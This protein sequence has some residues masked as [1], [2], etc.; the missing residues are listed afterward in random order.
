[1]WFC[2]VKC[3]VKIDKITFWCN[4]IFFFELLLVVKDTIHPNCPI[5]TIGPCN[6]GP[7]VLWKLNIS[8]RASWKKCAHVNVPSS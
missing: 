5:A 6:M 3:Y 1:M 7:Q 2:I 4:K 8:Q